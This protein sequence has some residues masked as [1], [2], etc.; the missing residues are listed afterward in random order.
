MKANVITAHGPARAVF[1]IREI[2]EPVPAADDLILKVLTTSI[3]PLD[4]RI[5]TKASVPRQFPV[6]LGFDVCG[7]VVAMGSNVKG[8]AVGDRVIG[9]PSPF[10]NG[11]N[12]EYV[13]MDHRSCALAGALDDN[14]AAAIP[15]VGIT[16]YEAL[17]DRLAIQ[18]GDLVVIHA[19]AGGVGHLAIQLAKNAGCTVITTASRSESMAYCSGELGADHV[20]NY[21][22]EDVTSRIMDLTGGQGAALILDTVGGATFKQCIEYAAYN[23]KICT[24]LPVAT[25]EREGYRLLLKN[26]TLSYQFMGG[27][28]QN[29][30]DNRQG[31]ILEKL[32]ALVE[33]GALQTHISGVYA[34]EEL[35]LA[36][37]Q[38][39][40]G[41]TIGK[42]VVRVAEND[43]MYT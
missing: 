28:L 42:L 35:P 22:K 8:F 11:A 25:D 4:C 19:G 26:T 16:A 17:F 34:L 32:V 6:V 33:S 37:E 29:P 31:K 18:M 39:E 23:G 21:Q 9:S 15:L 14:T 40:K 36:H 30:A 24:I 12:A 2:P 5:R 43:K 10:R 3:N 20:I 13:A 1:E 38:M 7:V 27:P 41:H